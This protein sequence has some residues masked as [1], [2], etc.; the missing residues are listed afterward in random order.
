MSW[1]LGMCVA[2][3]RSCLLFWPCLKGCTWALP[4]SHIFTQ[5]PLRPGH[6]LQPVS[7]GGKGGA[8]PPQIR[9]AWLPQEEALDASQHIWR[10]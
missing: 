6:S 1:A 10:S 9:K 5:G 2:Q 7:L 8:P 3:L 4:P